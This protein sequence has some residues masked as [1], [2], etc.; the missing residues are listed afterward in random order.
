ME[1]AL[2]DCLKYLNLDGIVAG[3]ASQNTS[4][5]RGFGQQFT[6]SDFS[7]PEMAPMSAGGGVGDGELWWGDD[8][9]ADGNESDE[10]GMSVE[11]Q[12]LAGGGGGQGGGAGAGATMQEPLLLQDE[13]GEV[14]ST[15]SSRGRRGGPELRRRSSIGRVAYR[16]GLSAHDAAEIVNN[17]ES[18]QTTEPPM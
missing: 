16:W 2:T 11:D 6:A 10:S 3:T 1:L 14:T 18:S 9:Y 5:L 4:P 8:M 13:E 12:P 7:T 15:W 17:F